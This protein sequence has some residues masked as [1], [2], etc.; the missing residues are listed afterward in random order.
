MRNAF[1][2]DYT[3]I[4]QT[5]VLFTALLLALAGPASGA[6]SYQLDGNDALLNNLK[7][8]KGKGVYIKLV[9]GEEIGGR[10]KHVGNSMIHIEKIINKEF[11]DALIRLDNIA[12]IRFRARSKL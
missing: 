9:S 3:S 2:T 5:G 10:I 7:M 1:R 11:Y 4:W 8:F 12:G 6:E